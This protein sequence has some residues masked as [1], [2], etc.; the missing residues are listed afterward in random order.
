MLSE[1]AKGFCSAMIWTKDQTHVINSHL[2]L[3]NEDDRAFYCWKPKDFKPA[4]FMDWMARQGEKDCFF[5][6]SLSRANI[7]FRAAFVGFDNGGLKFRMPEKI[8]K[9]QRR[10]DL[11]FGI[12]D[13][14]VL[15]VDF[16]DPLFPENLLSKK[17]IDISAGGCAFLVAFEES[18]IFQPGVVLKNLALEIR[19]REIKVEAEV[20]HI[21]EFKDGRRSGLVKIGVQFRGIRPGDAQAIASYVFEESR[22]HYAKF[23]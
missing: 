8:F 5:S 21:A 10:K 15:R 4:E 12:P 17:V 23:I 9:V 6:V 14:Y 18:I 2:S 20:R 3:F 16:S 19:G 1:G 7:F 11:R 22:R 13:G